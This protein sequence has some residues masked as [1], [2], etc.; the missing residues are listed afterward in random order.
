MIGSLGRWPRC[1]TDTGYMM[2][3]FDSFDYQA[4]QK[5][6]ETVTWSCSQI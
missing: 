2:V 1:I 4:E 5:A 6:K 3:L